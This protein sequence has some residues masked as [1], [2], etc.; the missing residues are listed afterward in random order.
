MTPK[1]FVTR[2]IPEN[3]LEMMRASLDVDVWEPEIPPTNDEIVEC[4]EDCVG[5]VPLLS[6]KI[7]ST[8]LGRLPKIR[9]IAQYAVGYDNIDVSFATSNGII[10]TNTPG[11]LT[12]TAADLAWALIMACSRRI[13]EADRYVRAGRWNVAWGPKMLLGT[14]IHGRTLGIVGL[15]RIGAAVAK[16]AAGFSMK[17]LYTS[18]SQ[19]ERTEMIEKETGAIGTDL[20]SLLKQADIVSIHVPLTSETRGL[21]GRDELAMM[22]KNSV[23]VNTSRGPVV[24]ERALVDAL[25]SGHLHSAG[26]D[27]FNQEPVSKDSPLLRLENVV[28]APHIGSA[29]IVTRAKMAEICATN[30]IAAL[31]GERPPNVVNPEV[32][33]RDE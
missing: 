8:L 24:E 1:V 4:A 6:D 17:I 18:R 26:L 11:V 7:D 29:S 3:G 22:K 5:L 32:F 33:E 30:L 12:E 19:T 14:D 16:R 15:G 25:R 13:P 28:L 20:V 21:I 23:L 27:V 9:V 10:V 31:K 2:M